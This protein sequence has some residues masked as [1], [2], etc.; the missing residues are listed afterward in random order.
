MLPRYATR[1]SIV[2]RLARFELDRGAPGTLPSAVEGTLQLCVREKKKRREGV[3]LALRVLYEAYARERGRASP[4]RQGGA[5]ERE[6]EQEGAYDAA[7]LTLLRALRDGLESSE[8]ALFT[9]VVLGACL[10]Y[11]S[12]SPRDRSLSRMPSSA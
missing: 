4:S 10:L 7:L 3:E 8:K 11:T 5:E 1:D 6:Q 2:S 9:E 12:P